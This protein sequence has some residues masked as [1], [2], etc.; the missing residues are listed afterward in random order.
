MASP[1]PS[2][3]AKGTRWGSF[4]SQAVAGVEAR[5][6]TILAESDEA[7]KDAAKDVPAKLAA[8]T[9]QPVKAASTPRSGSANRANDRLQEKLARAVAAKSGAASPGLGSFTTSTP[10]S[11]SPRQS[12]DV[13]SRAS[14]DSAG[15]GV[16]DSLSGIDLTAVWQSTEASKRPSFESTAA[17]TDEDGKKLRTAEKGAAADGISAETGGASIAAAAEAQSAPAGETTAPSGQ[18]E[19]P[20]V[21]GLSTAALDAV[22]D[23][24]IKQLEEELEEDRRQHQ[25]DIHHHIEKQ[26]ALQS[27][28][29]YLSR[30]ASEAAKK[31]IQSAEPG[32]LE[33]KLAEKDQLIVQLLEEG[34][35]L[36]VTE[37]KHRTILKKLRAKISEHEKEIADLTAARSRADAEVQTQRARARHASELE[38]SLDEAHKRTREL[39]K[40]TESLRSDAVSKTAAIADLKQQL[41]AA[42]DHAEAIKV[43]INDAA[44][45]KERQ[46]AKELEEQ[47]ATLQLE[48]SLVADRAKAQINE[49][50]EK[51]E[52][53]TERAHMV[54]VESKAEAQMMESK[55]EAMR[56]RAEE[57][58]SG[59]VGDS[60]AKLMRQVETL[61]SQYAI[62]SGN[63]QGIESTLLARVSSLEKERDEA[64][65]RESEMR[66]KAREAVSPTRL[67]FLP[68]RR[69]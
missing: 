65:Q 50:K 63:W 53:A 57:A 64:L 40:E 67:S 58:A 33:K 49:W 34:R 48:K 25:D 12:I 2:S 7:A 17:E 51:A 24:R 38:R 39:Q 61:Q 62:A 20:A 66:K 16:K 9:S 41:K 60:Q 15:T 52:R 14:M 21:S 27:K 47:L 6:D 19:P 30:E 13:P 45:E 5:L 55:L 42:Q 4:L 29:Q 46:R 28:V 59:A 68:S 18:A 35:N 32:S 36:G 44:L 56:V 26:E 10:A 22:R 11:A 23:A 69:W 54:E 31:A 1:P 37:Q 43:R 8:A 3:S